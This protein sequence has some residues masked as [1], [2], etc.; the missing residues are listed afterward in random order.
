M[1]DGAEVAADGRG[2]QRQG[3]AIA[4]ADVLTA[5]DGHRANEIVARDRGRGA[6]H[7]GQGDGV[8]AAHSQSGGARNA[9][10]AVGNLRE[11]ASQVEVEVATQVAVAQH[12]TTDIVQAHMSGA[13]NDQ[14]AQVIGGMVKGGVGAAKGQ[15]GRAGDR[16]LATVGERPASGDAELVGRGGAQLHSPTGMECQRVAERAVQVERV[17]ICQCGA[18]GMEG[19]RTEEVVACT[20]QCHGMACGRDAAGTRHLQ[21][22]HIGHGPGGV[23][24]QMTAN[25]HGLCG[26]GRQHHRSAGCQIQVKAGGGIAQGDGAPGQTDRP[27]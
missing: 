24:S 9:Q 17:D 15:R 19:D 7:V 2:R 22:A 16:E 10:T 8:G 21:S 5:G 13:G 26:R 18:V 25:G 23:Q 3:I 20:V 27:A 6:V 1:R 12:Q 11:G 14:R 4:Q